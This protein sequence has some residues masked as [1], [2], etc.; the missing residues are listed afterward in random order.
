MGEGEV[1][2]RSDTSP[3]EPWQDYSTPEAISDA[4]FGKRHGQSKVN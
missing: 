1:S 3:L 2:E 4:N